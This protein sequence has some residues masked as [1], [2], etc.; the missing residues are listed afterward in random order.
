MQGHPRHHAEPHWGLSADDAPAAIPPPPRAGAG[1][2]E[3]VPTQAQQG[4][5]FFGTALC[6]ERIVFRSKATDLIEGLESPISPSRILTRHAQPAKKPKPHQGN[7]RT[8]KLSALRVQNSQRPDSDRTCILIML[9]KGD[10]LL[11]ILPTIRA[12]PFENTCRNHKIR[13]VRT[14]SSLTRPPPPINQERSN[15]ENPLRGISLFQAL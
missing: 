8:V 6:G 4:E 14:P 9:I 1:A 7:Q 12:W 2:R 15:A 10:E 3:P 5:A 11:V 13:G